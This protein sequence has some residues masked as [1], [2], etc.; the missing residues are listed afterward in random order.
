MVH[1][2]IEYYA[3][4][5]NHMAEKYLAEW[6]DVQLFSPPPQFSIRWHKCWNYPTMIL[7]QFY[8][9]SPESHGEHPWNEGKDRNSQQWNSGYNKKPRGNLNFENYNNGNLRVQWMGSTAEW[10][11]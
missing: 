5:K 4:I 1:H 6:K 8:K 7:R 11:G 10:K 3:A 2:A 9:N